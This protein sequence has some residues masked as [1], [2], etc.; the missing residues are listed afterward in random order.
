[1]FADSTVGWIEY[2]TGKGA[3]LWVL[4]ANKLSF[5]TIP[6]NIEVT[7]EAFESAGT[8]AISGTVSFERASDRNDAHREIATAGIRHACEHMLHF[9]TTVAGTICSEVYFEVAYRLQGNT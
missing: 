5:H 6:D 7:T 4:C 8:V 1:M 3:A 2:L 9:A